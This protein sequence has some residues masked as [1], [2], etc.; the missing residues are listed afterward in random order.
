MNQSTP[1]ISVIIPTYNRAHIIGDTLAS[2]KAQTYPNWECIVVDDGGDDDTALVMGKFTET[3]HRFRYFSRP[4]NKIK[5]PCSCRNFG[6]QKAKGTFINFFDSDDLFKPFAFEHWLK[7]FHPKTDAVVAKTELVDFNS[8]T[9]M[10][11]YEIYSETLLEDFFIG[12]INFFVCGPLW[13]QSFLVTQQHLFDEQLTNGDDW[14]FNLRQLYRNPRLEFLDEALMQ[15]RVHAN[16]LSK[17]RSKLN[18][19]E[20]ISYFNSMDCHLKEVKQFENVNSSRVNNYLMSRY[21][22]YLILALKHKFHVHFFLFRRLIIQEFKLSYYC[23][24]LKTT[25]GYMSYLLFK[26]GYRFLNFKSREN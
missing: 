18:K 19:L 20:L 13:R 5:G 4:E 7:E 9:I 24:M 16:S 1:M 15:N 23:Q 3:D 22:A 26:K 11:T 21:S 17:E 14:D 25:L 12:K 6:F 2:I 8:L 10:K